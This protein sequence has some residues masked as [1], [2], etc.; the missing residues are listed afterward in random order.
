MTGHRTFAHLA[1][2]LLASPAISASG[3]QFGRWIVELGPTTDDSVASTC[4]NAAEARAIAA[5][6]LQLAIELCR[7][8]VVDGDVPLAAG[9]IVTGPTAVVAERDELEHVVPLGVFKLG[10]ALPIDPDW[11]GRELARRVL[12]QINRSDDPSDPC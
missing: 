9:G 7:R 4:V 5:G 2:E 8:G 12:E 3:R 11:R 1:P 6:W 10:H